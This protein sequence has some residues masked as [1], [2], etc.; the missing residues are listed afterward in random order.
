MVIRLSIYIKNDL[1]FWA[2]FV[3]MIYLIGV[4]APLP[5]DTNIP[6]AFTQEIWS[7]NN[8]LYLNTQ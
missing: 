2:S 8:Y 3:K 4:G 7:S 5:H 1:K 6:S